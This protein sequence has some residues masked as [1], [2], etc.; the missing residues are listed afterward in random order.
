MSLA[1]KRVV[2]T[3]QPGRA[4][5]LSDLLRAEGAEV[6]ELPTIFI[7]PP[8]SWEAVDDS[9]RRLASGDFRWVAFTSVNAV[10]KFFSRLGRMPG[11]AF[12]STKVAAVGATTAA[13]LS[14]RGIEA[15]VVPESFTGTALAEA[16]GSGDGT[17]LLPRAQDVPPDMVEVLRANGWDT[18]E[19]AAY[20]TVPAT[21]DGP[22]ADA[23]RAGEFDIVTFTSAST[24]KGFVGMMGAP[25]A[26]GLGTADAPERLVACIG[27][28]T[29]A[30]CAA[31]G[32][33]VDVVAS[34]HT[35][36]G[37]VAALAMAT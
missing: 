11:D 4:G 13:A 20:R 32:M 18:C 12:G 30:E 31:G 28:I 5:S 21:P 14:E 17:I 6:I 2:V 25:S 1:G 24:V 37:L 26:L 22:A 15:D 23:V 3:R 16:L 27:P 29:A 33:R 35:A 8:A 36:T 7:E 9:I 10:E 19:V 34:E